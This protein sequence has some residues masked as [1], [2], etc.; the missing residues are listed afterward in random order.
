VKSAHSVI[1]GVAWPLHGGSS[2]MQFPIRLQPSLPR[3]WHAFLDSTQT[4]LAMAG[5]ALSRSQPLRGLV[6]LAL[7]ALGMLWLEWADEL[8]PRFAI[9]SFVLAFGLR[10]AYLFASFNPDGIA[11]WLKARFGPER[12]FSLHESVLTALLF[13]QRSSFLAVLY[14]TARPASGPIGTLLVSAGALLTLLGLGINVWAAR[15]VGIDTYHYRDLF[16]GPQHVSVELRGPY[17]FLRNPMYG[18]GQLVGYGLALLALSP[19]GLIAAALNQVTLYLFNDAVEQPRLRA[20]TGVFM[21]T[22]LRYALSRT[23]IDDPRSSL[24]RRRSSRPPPR[25]PR[26]PH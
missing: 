12:A 23:L 4:A 22:Q 10:Y 13:A 14:T 16:M 7:L 19:I 9:S 18:M 6:S 15:V 20:A 1:T 25:I 8:S 3:A 5:L 2:A 11:P 24:Q 17:A 26:A 21:E